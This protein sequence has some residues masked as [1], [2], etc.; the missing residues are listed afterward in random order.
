[1]RAVTDAAFAARGPLV[2][3]SGRE[4]SAR[5]WDT[6]TWQEVG[7]P[8]RGHNGQLLAIAFDGSDRAGGRIATAS[9]DQTARVW[10]LR[11]GRPVILFG[12]EGPVNDVAFGP[13]GVAATASGDATARTWRANGDSARI[14]LGHT[15]PVRKVEFGS[16]GTVVTGGA[17]G[18]IRIWD[19]GTSI[20]LVRAP[21]ARG[22]SRPLRRVVSADGAA[23]ATAEG[24]AIV[25]RTRAGETLLEGHNDEVNSVSFSPDGR[26]L[27]SAG[28]DHDVIVWDVATGRKVFKREEAQSASVED[29][30]FSPDGRWLVTAG[31]KSA[32]LWTAD[33]KSVRYLYGPKPTVTAVGFDP[34]SRAV[35][36]REEDGTVRRWACE[37][38]GG[39]DELIAL[40]KARLRATRRRLTAEERVRYLG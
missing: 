9:T 37:L 3:S 8:L 11:T 22:P 29:A 10:R 14:L 23:S 5:I 31:P 13:G 20:E 4:W 19:P 33:G 7:E 30:R 21:N 26:R 15:G 16:D 39:L 32:R 25:L 12:H 35:L 40:G 6:R 36:T 2:A 27:V 17:D 38:C 24:N 18:T 28:R 34:R 1:V